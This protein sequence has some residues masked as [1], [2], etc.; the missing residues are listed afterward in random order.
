MR[1]PGQ[2]GSAAPDVPRGSESRL[3]TFSFVLGAALVAAY[4]ICF[5][6]GGVH[7]D[8]SSDD[9]M[10]M[11]RA[12]VRGTTWKHLADSVLVFVPAERPFGAFLYR[13][14]YDFAG[15]YPF[16]LHLICFLVA[17]LNVA[18]LFRVAAK[19]SSSL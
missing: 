1:L 16:P 19:L 7:A 14:T 5:A 18:L 8:F 9:L 6:G 4:F 15:L 10:N 2:R 11:N 12:L 3:R 13:L 17:L